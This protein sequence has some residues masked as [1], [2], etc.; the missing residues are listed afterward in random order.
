[1]SL[2]LN[3]SYTLLAHVLQTIEM[4]NPQAYLSLSQEL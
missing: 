4:H 3:S 1:M 2:V